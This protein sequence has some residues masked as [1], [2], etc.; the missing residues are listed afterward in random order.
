MFKIEYGKIFITRGDSAAFDIQVRQPD[1]RTIY[2]LSDGDVLTFTVKASDTEIEYLLQKT[3][4]TIHIDPVDTQKLAYGRYLYD[5]QL[6]F[7]DG[8]INTI[9]P[10]TPFI[11]C[12]EITFGQEVLDE[13]GKPVTSVSCDRKHGVH[14]FWSGARQLVGIVNLST[15]KQYTPPSP[16]ENGATPD[17]ILKGYEAYNDSG[18]VIVGT[19]DV[20]DLKYDFG[21][22][23]KLDGEPSANLHAATKQYVDNKQKSVTV[24]LTVANWSSSNTQTVTVN[25]V[26]AS[27]M[28]FIAPAPASFL[29]YCD[30]QVRAT[31]QAA[32]SLTFTCESKPEAALTV[33]IG[34][35]G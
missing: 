23:L 5:I 24:T 29:A 26:T 33:N 19:L 7:A 6:T 35:F 20:D 27:N 16:L 2:E 25:G 8:T 32:N 9:I 34:I 1:K 22:G 3:G 11:V 18:D 13:D 17:E 4:Q 31:T 15:Y 12:N 28:V 14:S 21:E 10:P 30:A